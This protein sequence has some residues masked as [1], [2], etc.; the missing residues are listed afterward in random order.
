MVRERRVP[1]LS[2]GAARIPRLSSRARLRAALIENIAERHF[3]GGAL[4]LAEP[5]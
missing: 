3:G 5:V 4:T 1:A 2:G